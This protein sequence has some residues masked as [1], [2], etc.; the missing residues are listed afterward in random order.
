MN[1]LKK[2]LSVLLVGVL[3]V[4]AGCSAGPTPKQVT[5]DF[6]KA[7]QDGDIETAKTF[8][9]SDKNLVENYFENEEAEKTAKL[10][11]SRITYEVGDYS[12]D[13]DTAVVN[14]KITSPDLLRIVGKAIQEML[15]MAFAAAFSESTS[16][17]AV[18]KML[19]QYLENSISDP[20]AP[21]TTSQ[22]KINLVK[23][24]GT[25]KISQDNDDLLNAVTGNIA[26]AFS[27]VGNEP[28]AEGSEQSSEATGQQEKAKIYSIG[29]KVT[30]GNVAITV[31]SVRTSTGG[32]W[33]KAKEGHIYVIPDITVENL[34]DETINL[35]SMMQFSLYDSE[36]YELNQA[37][38]TDIKSSLD[39]EI[40]PS[41]KLRGEIAWEVS[42]D[43]TGLELVF[44]PDIFRGGQV[45]YAIGDV[46]SLK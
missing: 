42:K 46:A 40:G 30:I 38:L 9:V 29:D 13:G 3:V 1:L 14:A 33:D 18:D 36:G 8:V 10:I 2:Y 43:A 11:L 34:G 35:S 4:I 41:R 39:G 27:M 24:N 31:N 5:N 32:E 20:N 16:Q 23:A 21:M 45:I 44:T 28:S 26:K 7:L 25:W 6:L 15:P 12:V 22:V 19:E 17:E 37:F